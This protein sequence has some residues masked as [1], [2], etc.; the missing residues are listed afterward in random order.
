MGVGYGPSRCLSWDLH[1]SQYIINHENR[2]DNRECPRAP[3]VV[4]TLCLQRQRY[5][6]TAGKAGR[7]SWLFEIMDSLKTP[8]WSAESNDYAFLDSIFDVTV[9][10]EY[11]Q[12]ITTITDLPIVAKGVLSGVDAVK[13]LESGCK[14]IYVSSHGGRQLDAIPSS[15]SV[16]SEVVKAVNGRAE[17]Y[18]DGGVR[19]GTDVL[20]ALALGAR[21]VFVGRPPLYGLAV[22]GEE[23][24]RNVLTILRNELKLAMQLSGV[25]DVEDVPQSLVTYAARL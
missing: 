16:L 12:W 24:A 23:G 17:V 2:A 4:S 8:L 13:A 19:T 7:E 11:I 5:D 6:Q 3:S 14:A 21:A 22:A 25:T 20:K 15:I 9:T 18:L 1:V 10:C